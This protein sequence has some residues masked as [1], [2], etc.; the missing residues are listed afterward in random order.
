MGIPAV[1]VVQAKQE[2]L[3]RDGTLQI[4]VQGVENNVEC[5]VRVHYSGNGPYKVAYSIHSPGVHL[6]SILANN[7][8]ISGSPFRLTALLGPTANK[9]HM[10]GPI[11]QPNAVLMIGNPMDFSVDASEAGAGTLSVKAIGPGGAQARVHVAKGSKKGIHD[12]KLD[13]VRHGIYRVSVKWSE[14]HI[15]GSPFML[16]IYPGADASKCNAFGPGLGDGYVGKESTF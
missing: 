9:C 5:K 1:F 6:I 13:P 11:L 4:K 3:L 14:K 12:I 16:K 8:H 15:P 7:K 10:Y 2:G